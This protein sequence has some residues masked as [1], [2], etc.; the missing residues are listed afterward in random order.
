MSTETPITDSAEF[1]IEQNSFQAGI[2]VVTSSVARTIERELSALRAENERLDKQIGKLTEECMLAKSALAQEWERAKE[3]CAKV[4]LDHPEAS[5][6]YL[7]DVIR[8]LRSD[9][10]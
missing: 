2:K 4:C 5:A 6:A 9:H 10:D 7:Y 8:A 1:T 3:K